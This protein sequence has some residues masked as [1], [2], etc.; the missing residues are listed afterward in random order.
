MV[1]CLVSLVARKCCIFCYLKSVE[2]SPDFYVSCYHSREI[3]VYAYIQFNPVSYVWEELF[4]YGCLRTIF[5]F[6]SPF[7]CR[8]F[9]YFAVQRTLWN[10]VEG[11]RMSLLHAAAFANLSAS[12][13]P[14]IPIW[15][16]IHENSIVQLVPSKIDILFLISLMR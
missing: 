6:F 14:Y 1:Y 16:L 2:I 13:F 3:R 4:C 7:L 9:F 12:S 10:P 11:D 8:S 15:A 5:P